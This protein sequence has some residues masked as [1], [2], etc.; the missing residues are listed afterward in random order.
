[1]TLRFGGAPNL[2]TFWKATTCQQKDLQL[3]GDPPVD[4]GFSQLANQLPV[5]WRFAA[6]DQETC[7]FDWFGPKPFRGREFAAMAIEHSSNW[8]VPTVICSTELRKVAAFHGTTGLEFV[9]VSVSLVVSA[10][11]VEKAILQLRC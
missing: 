11:S 5:P 9:A 7:R 8:S 6:E 4:D 3:L 2:V 10:I 1:M